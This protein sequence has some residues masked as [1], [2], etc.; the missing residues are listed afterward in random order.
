MT[1]D[2]ELQYKDKFR[3]GTPD[4]NEN[5]TEPNSKQE[6]QRLAT[7]NAISIDKSEEIPDQL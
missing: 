2:R 3:A 1:D 4:A 7:Q 5:N 6:L